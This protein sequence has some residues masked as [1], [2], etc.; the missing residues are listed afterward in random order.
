MSDMMK[1]NVIG[2]IFWV[3]KA[4]WEL[5]QF[6]G[7]E[8]SMHKGSSYNSCLLQEKKIVLV[9]TVWNPFT[10]GFVANLKNEVNPNSIGYIYAKHIEVDHGGTLP[11]LMSLI[12]DI[13]VYCT[14]NVIKCLYGHNQRGL[15]YSGG[16]RRIAV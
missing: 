5:R 6:H 1:T 7:N 12:P 9:D 15:G 13:P 8:Y 3:G 10:K 2:N 14:E 4:D 11:E 16:D